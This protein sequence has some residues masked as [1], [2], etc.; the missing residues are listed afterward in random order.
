MPL[1]TQTPFPQASNTSTS[2]CH[3]SFAFLKC[4]INKNT[5]CLLFCIY[6]LSHSRKFLILILLCVSLIL[7]HFIVEWYST[8]GIYHDFYVHSPGGIEINFR[9]ELLYIKKLQMLTKSY[10]IDIY[11]HLSWVNI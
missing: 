11:F 5:H 2:L 4:D 1:C 3:C 9:L 6:L 8:V 7:F 10:C